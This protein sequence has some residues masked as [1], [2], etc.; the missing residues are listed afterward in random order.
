V[1]NPSTSVNVAIQRPIGNLNH[2][3]Y[4]PGGTRLAIC[5]SDSSR[6]T[7][8]DAARDEKVGFLDHESGATQK[9]DFSPSGN[10][11]ASTG[12]DNTVRIWDVRELQ[13]VD[14]V[15]LPDRGWAVAYSP[16][17]EMLASGGRFPEII[18]QDLPTGQVRRISSPSSTW[19]LAFSPDGQILASAHSDARIRFWDPKTGYL[20]AELRGHEDCVNCLAFSPCGETLASAG[21]DG[22][23]RLWS[24]KMQCQYGVV[25]RSL[26]SATAVEF[27]PDGRGL[28]A[29]FQGVANEPAVMLWEFER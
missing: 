28:A 4:S 22:S 24:V 23:V 16:D 5:A 10:H 14:R 25:F 21:D 2:V 6:I 9:A 13:E 12:D 3:A 29:A 18:M 11:L 26:R 7:I 17:G 19:D 20:L 15:K 8:W 27:T 1:G